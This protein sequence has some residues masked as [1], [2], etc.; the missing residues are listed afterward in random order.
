MGLDMYLTAKQWLASWKDDEA[1]MRTEVG[2]IINAALPVTEVAMDAAY[3]RKANAIHKWFV[4]NV[5]DGEDNCREYY[6]SREKLAELL[7]ICQSLH[8]SK[9]IEKAMEWLPPQEGFFFG[10][11]EIDDYYWEDIQSTIDQLKALPIEDNR[12]DFYYR[13]SW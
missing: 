12:L 13:S 5:Q 3:W 11:T 2:K 10:S 1:A 6:V 4:N 7:D 9:D 8:E